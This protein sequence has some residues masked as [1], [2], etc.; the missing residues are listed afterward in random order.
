MLQWLDVFPFRVVDSDRTQMKIKLLR[1][2]TSSGFLGLRASS[3]GLRA[4]LV[5]TI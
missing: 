5:S 4:L 1:A 2:R 3:A